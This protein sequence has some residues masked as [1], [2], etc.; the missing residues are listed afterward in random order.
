MPQF[1]PPNLN[2]LGAYAQGAALQQQQLQEERL[3][4]QM[5]LAERSAAYTANKDIRETELAQS[6]LYGQQ[7]ENLAK[8]RS[9]LREDLASVNSQE[10]TDRI[11][12]KYVPIAGDIL[13]QDR[14]YSEANKKK[15][16]LGQINI[17]KPPSLLNAKNKRQTV[18]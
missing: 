1:Q 5:D 6:R 13:P 17:L 10:E 16:L 18:Q 4:Q 9:Q 14:T 3:R 15:W 2:L 11:F 7:F 8:L 12:A